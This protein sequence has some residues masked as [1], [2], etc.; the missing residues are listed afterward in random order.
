MD[1]LISGAGIAGLTVAHWLRR[2]GMDAGDRRAGA[3]AGGRRLQDRRA[4]P[5]PQR[6]SRRMGIYDEVVAASTRMRGAVLVDE[7][8][9]E[10]GRM[11]GEEFGH[12]VGDDVEI[13]RGTLCEILRSRTDETRSSTAPASPPSNR[14]RR[15][16]GASRPRQ[17][18]HAEGLLGELRHVIL[19]VGRVVHGDEDLD[20]GVAG[21]GACSE[22]SARNVWIRSASGSAAAEV[23]G[24]GAGDRA[25][26][27]RAAAGEDVDAVVAHERVAVAGDHERRHHEVGQP[28]ERR[29]A[30]HRREQARGSCGTPKRR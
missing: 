8:G 29:V 1:V 3:V 13:V 26:P 19:V 20:A 14:H 21:G 7:D 4:W 15:R 23:E 2:F 16:P 25:R 22:R 5:R 17:R 27:R 6:C 11:S 12:R 28:L 9:G 30:R 24:V 10:I 18:H